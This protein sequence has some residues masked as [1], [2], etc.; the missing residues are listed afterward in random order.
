VERAVR[1]II[2]AHE[3]LARLERLCIEICEPGARALDELELYQNRIIQMKNLNVSLRGLQ[4]PADDSLGLQGEAM[5]L[6]FLRNM[7]LNAGRRSEREEEEEEARADRKTRSEQEEAVKRGLERAVQALGLEHSPI[8]NVMLEAINAVL[9]RR[10]YFF[11]FDAYYKG[12][13]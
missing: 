6:R 12:Y 13:Y 9:A 1:R 8:D 7:N 11:D 3:S 2:F 4:E 10:P 5:R